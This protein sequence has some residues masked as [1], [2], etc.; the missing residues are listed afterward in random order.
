MSITVVIVGVGI[1]AAL[2]VLIGLADGR[3][4]RR[5]WA[6]IARHRRELAA[7]EGELISAA[8]A[9]GCA[10]CKLLRERAEFGNEF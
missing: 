3:A 5:A 1:L 8:E 4:Q 6:R 9:R 10:A 7:W 2:A